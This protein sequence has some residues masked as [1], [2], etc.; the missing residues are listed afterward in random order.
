MPT[1]TQLFVYPVKSLRGISIPS[2][3]L[4]PYG[5]EY[6][7]QWMVINEKNTFVSQRKFS[8]MVLIHT[9]IEVNKLVLFVPSQPTIAPLEIP[10]NKNPAG[11]AFNA[12][13]WKDT[14]KVVDEGTIASQWITR[15]MGSNSPLRIVRM[16]P[17]HQ[18]PQSKPELLGADT[19][20]FFADAAPYLIA[21]E[22]SLQAVNQQLRQAKLEAVSI[23]R[24]RPNIVIEGLNAFA[25]HKIKSLEHTTYSLKHCYPCQRCVMPTVNIET[26]IRH[27]QQQPF[28]LIAEINSMPENSKA[29]AFGEN[30]ILT[31]GESEYIRVGDKLEASFNDDLIG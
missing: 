14:C 4:T 24:F 31:S 22:T 19:H 1:I 18:R 29:P 28:S 20:T 30:A 9:R 23:E 10:I 26:G 17:N 2:A 3:K 16:A 15:V 13:I 11:D 21:N 25:E 27:S 12:T 5:F 8:N 6:D 7:R